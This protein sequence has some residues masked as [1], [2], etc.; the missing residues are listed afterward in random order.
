MKKRKKQLNTLVTD[1]VS[2][3]AKRRARGKRRRF[4]QE[5]KQERYM[6][7]NNTCAYCGIGGKMTADHFIP[8]AKGGKSVDVLS[9]IIPACFRCNNGKGCKDAYEWYSK[10]KFFSQAR[11][12]KIK[13]IV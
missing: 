4:S 2:K 8:L 9:N 5:Q 1:H 6:L 7:F 11:W 13:L 10:Q 12:D 3:R